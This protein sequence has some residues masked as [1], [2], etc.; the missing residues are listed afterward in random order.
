MLDVLDCFAGGRLCD[1]LYTRATNVDIDFT[2]SFQVV[3][4]LV[5]LGHV[6]KMCQ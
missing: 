6:R 1:A 5:E 4:H 2:K 3:T